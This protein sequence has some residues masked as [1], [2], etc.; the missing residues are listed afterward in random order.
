MRISTLR[1]PMYLIQFVFWARD[2][3]IM[4]RNPK[5]VSILAQVTY[6]QGNSKMG[7]AH[8]EDTWLQCT[9]NK[10]ITFIDK[11]ISWAIVG[12]FCG[13]HQHALWHIQLSHEDA[14]LFLLKSNDGSFRHKS[15][16]WGFT[17]ASELNFPS[18]AIFLS[19][20]RPSRNQ[21]S[22]YFLLR[23]RHSA[24]W[25][26]QSLHQWYLPVSLS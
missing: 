17:P 19:S 5:Q 8:W 18:L 15:C 1:I 26:Y 11:G 9:F 25:S 4:W 12:Q 24:P 3:L 7:N 16:A 6:Q 23:R 10:N 22:L 2:F 13:R 21:W 20:A 14:H